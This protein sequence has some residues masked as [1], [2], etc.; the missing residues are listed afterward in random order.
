[1]TKKQTRR[2]GI[3]GLGSYL[4]KKV[5]TN[6]DLEKMV[7]TSDEWIR[8]RTGISERRIAEAGEATSDLAVHAARQAL[9]DA[10]LAPEDVE[11]IIVATISPDMQFPA[12]SCLVQVSLGANNAACFDINAACSGFI[13]GIIIAQQ[14]IANGSY[15]N[16]LVIGAELLSHFIDWKDRSTCVLFGDGAGAAVI[17]PVK[18]GGIISSYIGADGTKSDLLKVPAGG[19]RM[20]ATHK[21]VSEGLHY[22]KMEGNEVFKHAVR[23][24][25]DA[26]KQALHKA[27][28][29]CKDVNCLIPHQANIR[30]IEAAARRA[31]LSMDKVYVNVDRYGNMSAASTIVALCEAV[32]EGRIKKGDIIVLVA[33][34]SGFVWGSCVIKW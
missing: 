24:M 30:I 9:K 32:N 10:K 13:H 3:I 5:L 18:S 2:I 33:F 6:S 28:L 15:N 19:S 27:G 23:V 26:A 14:F 25:A 17:A 31:G 11:L 16:A 21:T 1:M 12:T 7:D 22:L 8:T 29:T 34:G 20:P 4:P